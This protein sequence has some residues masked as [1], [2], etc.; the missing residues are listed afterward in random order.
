MG[1]KM[2]YKLY[3]ND[4]SPFAARCRMQ[5]YAK[6]LDVEMLGVPGAISPEDFAK[7]SPMHKVPI[8]VVDDFTIPE[9]E[10]IAEYIEEVET[11]VSL[12]PEGVEERAKVRLLARIGDLYIMLALGK[13]FGQINPQGRDQE[14]VKFLFVELDKGLGWLAHY[15]DGSK[16][17]V[18][19]RLSLADCALVPMLFFASKITPLFGRE[20]VLC[21][22]PIV[23]SYFTQTLTDPAVARVHDEL[24][25]AFEEKMGG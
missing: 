5:F 13:L 25:K 1:E 3:N 9:S 22:T 10:V 15:L 12:L 4:L 24:E 11:A 20:C 6:G 19:D 14:L 16:Y 7:L 17:A 8:L 18:G 2:V 21:E 23:H